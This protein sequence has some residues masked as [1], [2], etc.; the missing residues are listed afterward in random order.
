M[1][2]QTSKPETEVFDTALAE[3]DAAP[4]ESARAQRRQ[5]P[6]IDPTDQVE[7]RNNTF[8]RLV[9]SSP[10]MMGYTIVWDAH[11]DVQLMD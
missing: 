7:V 8:G 9:Y 2:K 5:K 4:K 1:A 6:K 11:G 10:R 3:A